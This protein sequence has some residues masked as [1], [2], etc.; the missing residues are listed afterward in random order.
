MENFSPFFPDNQQGVTYTVNGI[1]PPTNNTSFY[2]SKDLY[3]TEELALD[4]ANNIG[5]SG[6]RRVLVSSLGDYKFSPCSDSL[7]YKEIMKS[8]HKITIERRY[9][10]YDPTENIYDIRDSFNDDLY[11]GFEYKDQI[12]KR[13]LS[14]VIFKDPIKDG[15][16]A[17]F[18]RVVYG[19]IESTKQIKNFANYTVKK[20][21]RSVF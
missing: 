2:N 19:L 9:Y 12:L 17:Y 5:C 7:E 3:D 11:N 14:N 4:R 6:Y 10:N 13:T 1:K 21:N 18:N 16:L 20:N 15:I 8:M